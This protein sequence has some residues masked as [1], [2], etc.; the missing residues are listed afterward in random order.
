MIF[1]GHF[2]FHDPTKKVGENK[3]LLVCTQEEECS[4]LRVA[5]AVMVDTF[6]NSLQLNLQKSICSEIIVCVWL[7][8]SSTVRASAEYN[9]SS[10]ESGSQGTYILPC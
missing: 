8:M 3:E 10:F 5:M 2:L 1:Y 7:L 4:C 9:Q 6:G